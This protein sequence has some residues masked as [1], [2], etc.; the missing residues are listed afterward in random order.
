M[1]VNSANHGLVSSGQWPKISWKISGLLQVVQLFRG[2]DEGGDREALAGQ[3]FEES[4]EGDQRRYPGN[5]PAGGGAQHLV[6]LAQLRNTVMGQAELV[7]AVQVFLARATFDH[8]QLA[9]DQG[10]PYRMLLP[11][12]NR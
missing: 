8:F 4:L 1:W 12:G 10:V 5:L 3:Q 2:A 6:D 9:S 7:D 11:A